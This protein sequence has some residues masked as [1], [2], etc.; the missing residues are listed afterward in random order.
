MLKI[1]KKERNTQI[2]YTKIPLKIEKNGV[3]A[4]M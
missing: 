2:K 4:N 3:N 1:N